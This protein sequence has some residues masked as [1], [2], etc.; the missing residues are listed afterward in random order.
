[1][2]D[3]SGNWSLSTTVPHSV[4]R[5]EDDSM[6]PIVTGKWTLAL[7][8]MDPDY[9]MTT[10]DVTECPGSVQTDAYVEVTSF[11]S[12]LPS[13]GLPVAA[14]A[15]LLGAGLL[16]STGIAIRKARQRQQ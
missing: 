12:T 2:T 13:T 7:D 15:S 16:T 4:I 8:I 5:T 3:E 9:P 6:V 14:L 11:P 1:M 10:F